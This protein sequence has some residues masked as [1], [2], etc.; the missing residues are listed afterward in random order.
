MPIWH[1]VPS[2]LDFLVGFLD[3]GRHLASIF[4]FVGRYLCCR[5]TSW[6]KLKKK[7]NNHNS[8]ILVLNL[9]TISVKLINC[10]VVTLS[11]LI[12]KF[13]LDICQEKITSDI[14]S[15]S[16]QLKQQKEESALRAEEKRLICMNALWRR[17]GSSVCVEKKNKLVSSN[18]LEWE[19]GTSL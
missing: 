6:N 14:G 12:K 16:K 8:F 5:S 1:L 19:D 9:L 13:A 10:P 18:S 7:W 11:P 2:A 15:V 3:V 17:M 4:F